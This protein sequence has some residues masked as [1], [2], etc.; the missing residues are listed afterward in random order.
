MDVKTP[1]HV[2]SNREAEKKG[3]LDPLFPL[4]HCI[5]RLFS[6]VVW[7]N[8][9]AYRYESEDQALCDLSHP[10]IQSSSPTHLQ[11]DVERRNQDV[12]SPPVDGFQATG[13]L[14]SIFG[15]PIL[16][17]IFTDPSN[18]FDPC[19]EE[20]SPEP[21]TDPAARVFDRLDERIEQKVSQRMGSCVISN[22]IQ[23]ARLMLHSLRDTIEYPV[24][25]LSA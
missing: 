24:A 7:L 2:P 17:H 15:N 1:G 21:V 11:L 4:L 22:Q 12:I 13:C 23:I 9:S 5:S 19:M 20:G 6:C 25:R 10:F 18:P 3:R 14:W 16:I 8:V